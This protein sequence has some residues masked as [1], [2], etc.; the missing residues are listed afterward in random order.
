MP[1]VLVTLQFHPVYLGS[2]IWINAA[3]FDL[4]TVIHVY[5]YL[6]LHFLAVSLDFFFSFCVRGLEC[7]VSPVIETAFWTRL[8][9]EKM[10]A[11]A[12]VSL[13]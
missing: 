9:T 7:V 12:A 10:D 11:V 3:A 1:V 5:S 8:P 4:C 13:D 6:I 2:A